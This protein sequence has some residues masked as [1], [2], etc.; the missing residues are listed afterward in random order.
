MIS[1]THVCQVWREVFTSRPSL[2]TNLDCADAGKALVY[3]ER[4]R[5]FPINL[6]LARTDG[7]SPSKPFFQ[8]TPRVIGRLKSLSIKATPKNLHSIT[9]HLSYPAP[10]LEKLSI[11]GGS[12][13]VPRHSPA[14]T[15]A[16]FNEDLSSLRKL[17]L[18]SVRTELP[19]R[20]MVNLTSFTLAHTPSGDIS[21]TELL[22]FFESAPRLRR[23]N[24]HSVTPTGTQSGRL[25]S[26][27]LLREMDITGSGRSSPLLDHLLIP[28]GAKLTT[29]IDFPCLLIEDHLPSSLGN[30]GNFSNFTTIKLYG[31]DTHPHI[32]FSGPNGQVTMITGAPRLCG[33]RLV[34]R[35]L[36]QFDTSRTER[37]E[38]DFGD[39]PSGDL[40]YKALLR[41]ENLRRL[42]LS[43]CRSP[44]TFIHSLHPSMSSSG[45]VVCPNLEE[46]VISGV[47]FDMEQ[48]I[49]VA[50]A[51]ALK[52]A[53]LECVRIID[54][55]TTTG[56]D[57]LELEKHVSR[58][59]YGPEVDGSNSGNGDNEGD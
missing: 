22:D 15:S 59:E 51:R 57:V 27:P 33:T 46:F 2:W 7:P 58:V 36:A 54:R 28:V 17:R 5:S 35:S 25:V 47:V 16:I 41:M 23:V 37:L 10:L 52:G 19:W 43:R 4:S 20:N 26:L 21:F 8:I 14:L 13:S 24:F 3:L 38:I 12:R 6:A 34:L 53:K 50:A 48:F 11:D 32:Q 55:Y 18:E 30:L 42:T 39:S 40:P 45:A 1:L 31:S 9:A 29:R 56:G 49:G 44:H